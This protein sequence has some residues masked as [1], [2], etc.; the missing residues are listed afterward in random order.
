MISQGLPGY[1]YR[2]TSYD[3]AEIADVDP[4]YG[5]QLTIPGF[6]NTLG[7]PESARLL[8]RAPRQWIQ[9]MEREEA[10]PAALQLQQG[11]WP[12]NL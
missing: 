8:S 11:A 10:V 12:D 3:S 1:P 9:T 5:L 7:L 4:A 6:W 2:M